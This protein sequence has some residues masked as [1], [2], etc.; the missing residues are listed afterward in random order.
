MSE[1]IFGHYPVSSKRLKTFLYLS[2][3][4]MCV[5][6]LGWDISTSDRSK[7]FSKHLLS[8]RYLWGSLDSNPGRDQV[9]AH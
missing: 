2:I 4:F 3:K 8:V 9:V 1:V 7:D 6:F 5:S